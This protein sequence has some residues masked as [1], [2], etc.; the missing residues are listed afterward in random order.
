MS[1]Y[2]FIASDYELQEIDSIWFGEN[3]FEE[4]FHKKIE[5]SK[6]NS[7]DFELLDQRDCC[8]INEG[9]HS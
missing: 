5:L 2:T 7:C 1:R 9:F 8:F 4:M 3:E 6:I